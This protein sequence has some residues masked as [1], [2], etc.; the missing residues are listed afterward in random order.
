MR[1]FRG[2]E[3]LHEAH[4][5]RH[6]FKH[7]S[8]VVRVNGDFDAKAILEFEISSTASSDSI[9]SSSSQSESCTALDACA[10]ECNRGDPRSVFL[11]LNLSRSDT[12]LR[13]RSSPIGCR[14]WVVP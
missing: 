13:M 10:A 4:N 3:F 5:V 1:I 14:V 2:H 12:C 9:P 6:R 11:A 8:G 7:L